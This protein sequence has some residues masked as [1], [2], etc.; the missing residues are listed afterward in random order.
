M[1]LRLQPDGAKQQ[2]RLQRHRCFP[3]TLSPP[4]LLL[5]AG[6]E[7]M[8]DPWISE[9][10]LHSDSRG[11]GVEFGAFARSPRT[12]ACIITTA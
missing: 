5:M 7:L 6:D 1:R 10:L 2:Q 11:D 9:F 4:W 12:L 8:V 3:P